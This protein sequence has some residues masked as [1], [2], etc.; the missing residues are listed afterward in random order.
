MRFFLD[1]GVPR[2][3][4]RFLQE[5][6][7]EVIFLEDRIAKGSKDTLV[8][9]VAQANHAILV[10]FDSDFKSIAQRAGVGQR[11]FKTLSILRFEKCRESRAVER[12]RKAL[13]LILH[14]WECGNGD[15]DRRM[16]VVIQKNTIRT[17]R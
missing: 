5:E 4:G 1:E 15:N 16:F 7:Y 11:R 8:A 12:L 3:V 13:S 10:T 2:S 6:G 17:H 14:E 9:A